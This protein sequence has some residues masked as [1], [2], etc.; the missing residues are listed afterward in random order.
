VAVPFRVIRKGHATATTTAK[1]TAPT[2][3]TPDATKAQ[4]PTGSDGWDAAGNEDW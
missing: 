4:A 2:S 3:T 1:T